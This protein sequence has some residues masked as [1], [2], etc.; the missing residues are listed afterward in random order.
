MSGQIERAITADI[1]IIGGG[2]G[3]VAA[4]LAA[5]RR[6]HR[7]TLSEEYSW[8]GGQ[9]TSQA[10]P[11]DEHIW[12]EQFGITASYRAL[13][14]GIRQYYRDFYPLT[15]AARKNPQLNPGLGRVS[16]LCHEPTVAVAAITQLLAP[17][18]SSGLLT[19]LQPYVPVTAKVSGDNV[20]SI[21]LRNVRTGNEVVVNAPLVLDA[22][23][24]GDLLPLTGTEYIVGS[25]SRGQ[26]GEPSAPETA[27]PSNVQSIAW[28]FVFD[29]VDGDHTIERPDDYEHWL[30]LAPSFWGGPMLS[31]T[32]PNPRTLEPEER[33]L[34]V[35]SS[36]GD[37]HAD[38]DPR[39]D[40]GD[41]DLWEFRRIVARQNFLP[42]SFPSDIVLA[43]WPSLDYLGGSVIDTPDRDF[44][45]AQAKAQSRAYFYWLQT[46]APRPDGG[47]GWPGLRLR[48]DVVGTD[49]GFAQAPYIRESRRIVAVTTVVEQDVSVVAR[50]DAGPARFPNSVGVG[51]YRI[52]LH[53]STGGDNYLDIECAPFEIPLGA[54]VPVRTR[55][56][57]PAAKNIGTTHITNGA[58]R[59]HP[60]EWNIGES[61]GELASYCLEQSMTP[62]DVLSDPGLVRQFQTRL[63]EVGVEI[64]WPEIVGY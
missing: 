14:E 39:F 59:L 16:Q 51:M 28:C 62:R 47:H 46:E 4:A 2:L 63:V 53:P 5:L 52:D 35:N 56:L 26:T 36:V 34:H 58:Y 7:V 3:G 23:E 12:V 61:A 38:G 40:P 50:G 37:D 11:P 60:V 48:G 45:L 8:L 25:E 17:Y 1:A 15:N 33:T 30:E 22:T 31:F 41:Q 21:T 9:L 18:C 6:G 54:L 27:D 44:H 42:G 20:D 64:H 43:N 49:D 55:N 57:I 29:H 32:A 24:T 19:V 10:V 13:R